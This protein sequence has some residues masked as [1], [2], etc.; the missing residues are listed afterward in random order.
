[1]P[2]CHRRPPP[3]ARLRCQAR[4]GAG[5]LVPGALRGSSVPEVPPP[6]P[7]GSRRL[8]TT[9]KKTW[10]HRG[11]LKR[12]SSERPPLHGR[13]ALAFVRCPNVQNGKREGFSRPWRRSPDRP[14]GRIR[15]ARFPCGRAPLRAAARS[16]AFRRV[17]L[18]GRRA[19]RPLA[20]A[21]LAPTIRAW[22]HDASP[23]CSRRARTPQAQRFQ[24]AHQ[25]KLLPL[26][27]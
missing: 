3:S 10:A 7:G 9:W 16:M 17:L 26:S 19:A 2:R 23:S 20:S 25:R 12:P 24:R 11:D 15:P 22:S 5:A 13:R 4:L 18:V 6:S 1:M 8:P 27:S 21:P 14:L